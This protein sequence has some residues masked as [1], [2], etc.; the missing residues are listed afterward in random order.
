[1][2]CACMG[3]GPN[4]GS[5]HGVK[6]TASSVA[7]ARGRAVFRKRHVSHVH[8][9]AVGSPHNCHLC[10]WIERIPGGTRGKVTVWKPGLWGAAAARFERGEERLPYQQKKNRD[11]HG[12]VL[13]LGLKR[14]RGGRQAGTAKRSAQG[15]RRQAACT[16]ALASPRS[17]ARCWRLILK[18]CSSFRK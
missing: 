11:E 2:F 6:K 16:F 5:V 13:G 9:A 3:P 14:V 17:L 1:M 12:H 18:I 8:I 7:P 4:I 15:S 10:G